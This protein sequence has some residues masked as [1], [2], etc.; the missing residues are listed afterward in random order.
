MRRMKINEVRCKAGCETKLF[1]LF[2]HLK[3]K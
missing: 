3:G 1:T 2:V